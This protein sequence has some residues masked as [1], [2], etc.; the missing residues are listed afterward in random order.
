MTRRRY[1]PH[2]HDYSACIAAIAAI[3]AGTLQATETER[4]AL[5]AVTGAYALGR[6]VAQ[7]TI[8]CAHDAIWRMYQITEQRNAVDQRELDDAILDDDDDIAT[9]GTLF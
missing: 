7:N 9:D 8:L 6:D 3:A 2:Q 4:L 1:R 5:S